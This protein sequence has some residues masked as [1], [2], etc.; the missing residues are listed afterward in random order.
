MSLINDAL[1]QAKAAQPAKAAP[2][3]GPALRPVDGARRSEGTGFLLP[4]LV[5]V[6]LALAVTLLW[7][8]FHSSGPAELA[9]R[10]RTVPEKVQV[11]PVPAPEPVKQVVEAPVAPQVKPFEP[12]TNATVTTAVPSIPNTNDS[13]VDATNAVTVVPKP[14]P[15]TYKLQGIFYN[16]KR[17]SAMVSGKTVFVGDH[18]KGAK[19]ISIQPESVTIMTPEGEKKVMELN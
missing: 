16:P 4:A 11:Q 10:A 9:V 7:I 12:A 2:A 18:V 6:I 1:K 15:P 19:V 17:P 14:E 13:A 8:W 3:D 5:V